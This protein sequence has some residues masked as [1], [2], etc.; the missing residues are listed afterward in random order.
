PVM[1][2]LLCNEAVA[3][4]GHGAGGNS[5]DVALW[6]CSAAAG[7]R[8]ALARYRRLGIV[9]F[10]HERRL[11]SVL[12]EDDRG[13]RVIIS[14]GAPEGLLEGC[15]DVPA[16]ART[17]LEAEFAAGNRVVAVATRDAPGRPSLIS[18]AQQ[19]LTLRGVLGF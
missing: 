17:M 6:E 11:V 14:K 1:L 7:Q 13:N 18:A 15:T 5:L 8:A 12:V 4:S 3:A 19:G 16:A 2:G 10:D 9:P